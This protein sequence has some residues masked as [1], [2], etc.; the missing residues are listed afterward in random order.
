MSGEPSSDARRLLQ[1]VK[2]GGGTSWTKLHER[3][4]GVGLHLHPDALLKALRE[5]QSRGL[6]VDQ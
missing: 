1:L 6:V 3:A 4:R 5:L 2:G